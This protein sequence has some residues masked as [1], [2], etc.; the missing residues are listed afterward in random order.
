MIP[1]NPVIMIASYLLP[2]IAHFSPYL[3]GPYTCWLIIQYNSYSL[4]SLY[5]TIDSYFNSFLGLLDIPHNSLVT[6]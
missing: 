3:K 5:T 4:I 6:C 1:L 2:C